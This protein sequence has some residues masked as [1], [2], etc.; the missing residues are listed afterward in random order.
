[1]YV[2]IRGDSK[3]AEGS[4]QAVACGQWTL[5]DQSTFTL[6]MLL[7][8]SRQSSQCG[9]FLVWAALWYISHYIR[10]VVT[11][12]KAQEEKTLSKIPLSLLISAPASSSAAISVCHLLTQRTFNCWLFLNGTSFWHQTDLYY[13]GYWTLLNDNTNPIMPGKPNLTET[14]QGVGESANVYSGTSHRWPLS[15][16][17]MPHSLALASCFQGIGKNR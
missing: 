16:S 5:A 15:F 1:M 11:A 14:T 9:A 13:F 4:G 8:P 12:S 17:D 6:P 3:K 2:T 7:H 10:S